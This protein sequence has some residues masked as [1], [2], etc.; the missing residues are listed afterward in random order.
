MEME[1]AMRQHWWTLV[2]RGVIGI[3][4]GVLAIIWPGITWL[5]L[6]MLFGAYSLVDG[7]FALI[8]AIT[9]HS[10]TNRWWALLLHGIVGIMIGLVTFFS[11]GLTALALIYLIGF[12]AIA[13]GVFE[14]F[15][16]IRLREHISGEVLLGISGLFSIIFGAAVLLMPLAGILATVWLIAVY[17]IVFGALLIALGFEVRGAAGRLARPGMGGTTSPN[18]RWPAGA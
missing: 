7:I 5:V 2:L 6:A 12:W 15:T 17:A 16:A 14:I 9:G 18:D 11:P 4:F 3:L 10:E 1:F 8:A 13:T